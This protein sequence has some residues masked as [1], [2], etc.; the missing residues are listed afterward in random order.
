[1]PFAKLIF[2]NDQPFHDGDHI[3]FAAKTVT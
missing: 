2:C 1:L 3:F